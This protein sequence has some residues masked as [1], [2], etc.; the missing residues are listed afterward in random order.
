MTLDTYPRRIQ[1]VSISGMHRIRDTHPPGHIRADEMAPPD[2][3]A[4]RT[5]VEGLVALLLLHAKEFRLLKNCSWAVE[6]I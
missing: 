1:A 6:F 3:M 5:K 2:E 4:E